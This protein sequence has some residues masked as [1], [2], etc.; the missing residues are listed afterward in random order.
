MTRRRAA[1]LLTGALLAL[2][3]MS[4]QAPTHAATAR[5]DDGFIAGKVVNQA[6]GKPIKGVTVK[7]FR[8][9][10]DTL[11]GS[12]VTGSEGRY[13]IN[14]LSADDEEL[15]IRV[16]GRAVEFEAGRVARNNH[17]VPSRADACSHAQGRQDPFLLQH[18]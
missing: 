17:V 16:N 13:R 15:D 18:L 1:A 7:V 8:I 3:V 10:T 5:T 6:N 12:D 4:I 11:L 2:P 9:N 14:G